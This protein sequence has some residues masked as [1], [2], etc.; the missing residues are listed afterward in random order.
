MWCLMNHSTLMVIFVVGLD[1]NLWYSSN[2]LSNWFF[3]TRINHTWL[4]YRPSWRTF[5]TYIMLFS[6]LVLNRGGCSVIL[7]SLSSMEPNAFW[8]TPLL[9]KGRCIW[10]ILEGFQIFKSMFFSSNVSQFVTHTFVVSCIYLC[11]F[12]VLVFSYPNKNLNRYSRNV[13]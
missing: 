4:L 3:K 1:V 8:R 6:V 5:S 9:L 7:V 11:E 10:G 13:N 12:E 2:F